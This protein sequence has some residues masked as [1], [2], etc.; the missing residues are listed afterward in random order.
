MT[1]LVDNLPAE[2]RNRPHPLWMS[3]QPERDQT[4]NQDNIIGQQ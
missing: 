3:S 2:T 1:G 4:A